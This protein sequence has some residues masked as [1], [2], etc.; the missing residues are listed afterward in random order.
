M[1]MRSGGGI[2]IFDP[3]REWRGWPGTV[4]DVAQIPAKVKEGNEVIIFHPNGDKREAIV[5]LLEYVHDLHRV[6]LEHG[7][8]KAGYHFTLIIDEAV[9][10]STARWIDDQTIS[11]VAENRPEI[12]SIFFTFQSP[13][14]ANNLLKSRIDS[15]YIFA[16]VRFFFIFKI[17]III[18]AT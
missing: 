14:D 18:I 15:W 13:K 9:N 12:L 6:A 17:K 4:E 16:F 11:L 5:P 8:D 3:K 2:I 7:W 10:V 1:A